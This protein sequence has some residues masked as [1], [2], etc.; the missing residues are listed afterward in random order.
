[1]LSPK[2]KQLSASLFDW[3]FASHMTPCVYRYPATHPEEL[4]A[5]RGILLDGK[6]NPKIT[7]PVWPRGRTQK[8]RFRTCSRSAI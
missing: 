5:E 1:V 4:S 7:P 6:S 2:H 3:R 8:R